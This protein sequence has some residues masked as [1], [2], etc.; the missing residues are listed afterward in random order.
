M[1]ELEK[2][3]IIST[4]VP[5]PT[6]PIQAVPRNKRV[7]V[8]NNWWVLLT[9]ECLV[10]FAAFVA[11]LAYYLLYVR[12][13]G[14]R[15]LKDKVDKDGLSHYSSKFSSRASS[16]ELRESSTPCTYSTAT[17]HSFAVNATGRTVDGSKSHRSMPEVAPAQNLHSKT[18]SNH[19]RD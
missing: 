12:T 9:I 3:D 19:K 4:P 14:K 11:L 16:V 17:K 7:W 5:F 13:P 1:S 18:T 15:L 6:I 8:Q 10:L 2:K